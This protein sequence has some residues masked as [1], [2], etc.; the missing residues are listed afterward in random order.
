MFLL[1]GL[2]NYGEAYRDTRHN[3]G[4]MLLDKIIAKYDLETC[5][6]K[7]KSDFFAGSFKSEKIIA[8]KPQTYMNLSGAAVASAANFFKI[9]KQKIIVMHDDLDLPLG[10]IK[11]KCGGGNAGHNGLKSIDECIGADYFRLRLGIGRPVNKNVSISDY[12]LSSFATPELP[13]VQK[14]I[15][16]IA[17]NFDLVFNEQHSQFLQKALF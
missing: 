5:G 12:V 16:N 11:I 1:V 4:F 13:L 10:K 15:D 2:G 14:V 17:S 8:I 9:Q 6:I 7:H 3:F